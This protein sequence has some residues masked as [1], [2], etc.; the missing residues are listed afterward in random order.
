MCKLC[1]S[2]KFVFRRES[3]EKP[4]CGHGGHRHGDRDRD[5]VTARRRVAHPAGVGRGGLIK[6]DRELVPPKSAV[7]TARRWSKRIYPYD[8]DVF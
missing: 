2:S 5:G 3:S 8:L 7:L 1:N 4:L 6:V